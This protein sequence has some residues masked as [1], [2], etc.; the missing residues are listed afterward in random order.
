MKVTVG[1]GPSH[2]AVEVKQEPESGD[3]YGEYGL[4]YDK[5]LIQKNKIYFS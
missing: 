2:A 4:G 1:V 5:L 3:D